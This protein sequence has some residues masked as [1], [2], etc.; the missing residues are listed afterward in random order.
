MMEDVQP[1]SWGAA[2]RKGRSE[3]SRGKRLDLALALG[4][5][6]GLL[7]LGNTLSEPEFPL[8][9]FDVIAELQ[10]VRE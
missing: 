6:S 5:G 10:S 9:P 7:L 4:S 8:C 2:I 1:G 3:H